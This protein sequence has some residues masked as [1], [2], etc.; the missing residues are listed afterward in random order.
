MWLTLF[1][2]VAGMAL[3]DYIE[4]VAGEIV[5]PTKVCPFLCCV[6]RHDTWV[7]LE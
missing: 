4:K 7:E 3:A 5:G 1:D 2:V 6:A